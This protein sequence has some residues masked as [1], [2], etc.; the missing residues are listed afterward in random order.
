MGEPRAA[1]VG[2]PEIGHAQEPGAVYEEIR[3]FY[4]AMNDAV[5]VGV[6]QSQ[7]RV[8]HVLDAPLAPE[9]SCDVAQPPAAVD[10]PVGDEGPALQLA[11]GAHAHDPGVIEGGA[12]IPLATEALDV[13]CARRAV[14]EL[15]GHFLAAFEVSRPIDDAVG[16]LPDDLLK[17]KAPADRREGQRSQ[18]TVD[19]PPRQGVVRRRQV[20]GFELPEGD[21]VVLSHG[22]SLA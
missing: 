15:E 1:Q 20:R 13:L 7:R 14:Q 3:R 21:R 11:L 2:D 4:V 12:D 18:R 17:A 19:R 6:A 16:P 8:A 22:P 9:V 10:E 5:G